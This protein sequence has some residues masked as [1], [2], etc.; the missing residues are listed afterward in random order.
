MNVCRKM[1]SRCGGLYFPIFDPR[2]PRV[3]HQVD[4]ADASNRDPQPPVRG[5]RPLGRTPALQSY[6][7]YSDHL[8]RSR[9][10]TP[11]KIASRFLPHL[12]TPAP[13]F[14]SCDSPRFKLHALQ[15]VC[16]GR[17]TLPLTHKL[18]PILLTLDSAQDQHAQSTRL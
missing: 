15:P 2:V 10:T 12:P 13:S 8:I 4:Q 5:S 16:H 6:L 14:P 1:S 7:H 11:P 3:V 9:W 17:R 18:Q